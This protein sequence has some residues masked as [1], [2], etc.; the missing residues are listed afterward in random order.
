M[1]AASVWYVQAPPRTEGDYRERAALAAETLRSQVQTGRLWVR[2]LEEG[3]VTR[4][5]AAVAFREAEGDAESA[6][7]E[8]AAFDPRGD[9]RETRSRVMELAAR[10]TDALG[11]LRIA[12][13]DGRW[14]ALPSLAAPLPGLARRLEATARRAEP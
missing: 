10:V 8:F 2:E 5:A 9:T 6:A 1:L 4:Q 12:S 13:Q 7:S 14:D 3:R 11:Q